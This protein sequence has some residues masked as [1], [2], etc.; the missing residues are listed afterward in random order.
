MITFSFSFLVGEDYMAT[1]IITH[2]LNHP[3]CTDIINI[4]I[5]DD[6]ILEAHKEI[7]IANLFTRDLGVSVEGNSTALIII[8]DNDGVLL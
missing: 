3:S 4:Q 6:R 5:I 1:S 2:I 7:F 8:E